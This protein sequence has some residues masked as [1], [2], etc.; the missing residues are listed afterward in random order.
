M[1]SWLAASAVSEGQRA[2][3]E[4]LGERELPQAG[5]LTLAEAGGFWAFRS[6]IHL[7]AIMHTEQNASQDFLRTRK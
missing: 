4:I 6:D 3:Q 5:E 1:A 2:G 7:N